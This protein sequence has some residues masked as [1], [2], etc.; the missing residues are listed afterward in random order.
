[1][2]V[3]HLASYIQDFGLSFVLGQLAFLFW[4]PRDLAWRQKKS[5]N[6]DVKGMLITQEHKH[7]NKKFIQPFTIN[8]WKVSVDL[9]ITSSFFAPCWSFYCGLGNLS[10]SIPYC[11]GSMDW[12]NKKNAKEIYKQECS[13]VL[14][15][16]QPKKWN[17]ERFEGF[18]ILKTAEGNSGVNRKQHD[19]YSLGGF[20]IQKKKKKE[21]P[22]R[23]QI[24][25]QNEYSTIQI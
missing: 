21:K 18:T 10:L 12:K 9:L 23:L 13:P 5:E 3:S 11:I 8:I 17:T 15:N 1:M 2:E 25:L 6:R 4:E 19:T 16:I 14:E 20:S 7:N 24:I 22:K